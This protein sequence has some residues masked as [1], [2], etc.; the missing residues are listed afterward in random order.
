MRLADNVGTEP[1]T[2]KKVFWVFLLELPY[3][4]KKKNS[5]EAHVD[6]FLIDLVFIRNPIH[7]SWENKMLW[8]TVLWGGHPRR[9]SI[10][11]LGPCQV[12]FC[13]FSL[14]FFSVDEVW[15]FDHQRILHKSA[16]PVSFK[17]DQGSGSS[18]PNFCLF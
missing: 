6:L 1:P 16:M 9:L 7:S 15:T 17:N 12:S 8:G 4:E 13:V 11:D 3:L 18:H 2:D 10:L 5:D 14:C